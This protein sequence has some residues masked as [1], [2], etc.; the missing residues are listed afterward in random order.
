MNKTII[1]LGGGV[2]QV[3]IISASLQLG[4]YTVVVDGNAR[5]IGRE[6]A[7]A[8]VH[9]D[10]RDIESIV[11]YIKQNCLHRNICLAVTAGTD[12]TVTMAAINSA[13]GLPGLQGSE[14]A[15]V[16]DK[17][18]MRTHLKKSGFRVPDFY[19]IRKQAKTKIHNH[20][21]NNMPIVLKP[22]NNMGGRGIRLI[23]NQQDL[24]R[25]IRD[26]RQY[27]TDGSVL[28]EERIIGEEYSIDT[29]VKFSRCTFRGIALRHISLAPYFIEMGHTIPAPRGRKYIAAIKRETKRAAHSF[30]I[31]I[32][33]MKLDMFFTSKP[34]I[35]ELAARLS[36]GF[37]SGWT[38]PLSSRRNPAYELLC[39]LANINPRAVTMN[40]RARLHVAGE[41]SVI[42][43]PGVIK[44]IVE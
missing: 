5:C 8:F 6:L 44:D 9:H 37:M 13:L 12:F 41:R 30:A 31:G 24:D 2:L 36:G 14:A 32:G 40:L 28:L 18:I 23:D 21:S 42:S 17:Y 27:S 22:L 38:Y 33:A 25:Y 10:L 34:V 4:F 11:E 7:D 20:F 35:G 15:R 19:L 16:T 1:V 3:P 39:A 26:S 43:I 29:L